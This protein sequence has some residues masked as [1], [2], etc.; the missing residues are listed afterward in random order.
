MGKFGILHFLILFSIISLVFYFISRKKVNSKLSKQ[1]EEQRMDRIRETRDER[2]EKY[3][4]GA[5]VEALVIE[6][7]MSDRGVIAGL[8]RTGVY[9]RLGGIATS[10]ERAWNGIPDFPIKHSMISIEGDIGIALNQDGSRFCIATHDG[11]AVRHE[12]FNAS[13]L[14]SV[15][16]EEDGDV[17]TKVTNST[18]MGSAIVGGLLLGG[19]GAIV[20][21]LVGRNE[22]KEVRSISSLSLKLLI[23]GGIQSTYNIF[24][25]KHSLISAKVAEYVDG[26]LSSRS[27]QYI[28]VLAKA[29]LWCDSLTVILKS[30][31]KPSAR[32]EDG[33]RSEASLDLDLKECPQCAERVR[34]NAKIC[35]YCRFEFSTLS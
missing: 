14:I 13:N 22:T 11:Q 20:G 24:F 18:K 1:M 2:A 28:N 7:N 10:I 19:V 6:Y 25:L 31:E 16:I 12:I 35:R 4:K 29:Q 17:V 32:S 8:S 15:E 5:T 21:G 27:D 3:L 34:V 26:N 9:N 23:G 30:S 33:V